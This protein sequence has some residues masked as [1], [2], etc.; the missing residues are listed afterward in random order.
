MMLTVGTRGSKLSVAQTETVLEALRTVNPDVEFKLKTIKTF[1]DKERTRPLFAIDRKGLFEREINQALLKGEVDFAVHSFKDVP[2]EAS[3]EIVVAAVPKRGSKNDALVSRNGISLTKLREGAVVGTGS[4]RRLAQ[5]KRYRADLEVKPVRG[6][7][8]SRIRKV[9]K[10]EFDAVIIAEAGL[11]RLGLTAK[12]SERLPLDCF[13]PAAGQG[14][15][16]VV[17]RKGEDDIVEFLRE[18][19]HEPSRAEVTAE[20]TLIQTLGGGCRVPISA[21]GNTEKNRLRLSGYV[22]SVDGK[23]ML[24]AHA[25]SDL[26]E[27]ETLGKMVAADLLRQGARDLEEEWRRKYDQR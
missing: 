7:L 19:D 20:R 16:A 17:A 22:F 23:N 24:A 5:V 15:L 2:T 13:P 25:E 26:A 6:N 8:D 21:V 12:M 1:G 27:A 14:A 11:E 4:L 10:G 3:D 18:I 9:E